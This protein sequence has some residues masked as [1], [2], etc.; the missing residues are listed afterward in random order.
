[1]RM[2]EQIL[3]PFSRGAPSIGTPSTY[4]KCE[5]QRDYAVNPFR[6]RSP[7]RLHSPA[8][9]RPS[10]RFPSGLRQRI[11]CVEQEDSLPTYTNSASHDF[12]ACWRV[13]VPLLLL[14]RPPLS[15]ALSVHSV[16]LAIPLCHLSVRYSLGER[17]E[18]RY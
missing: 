14:S 17:K 10:P 8:P 7:S 12:P 9:S 2:W 1:M 15:P 18:S 16:F 4:T 3:S 6:S 11:L 5:F 13:Y